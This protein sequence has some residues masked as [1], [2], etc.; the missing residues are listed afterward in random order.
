MDADAADA[1]FR[2]HAHVD[3]ENGPALVSPPELHHVG[4]LLVL[5]NALAGVGTDADALSSLSSQSQQTGTVQPKPGAP[6]NFFSGEEVGR[7]VENVVGAAV[8]RA[9][10]FTR[11]QL[12]ALSDA[13]SSRRWV[14]PDR[15]AHDAPEPEVRPTHIHSCHPA[16]RTSRDAT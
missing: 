12:A 16:P 6:V 13:L 15:L 5:G 2:T 14:A 8:E 10:H 9:Q 3:A 7:A 11:A 4:R 1:W